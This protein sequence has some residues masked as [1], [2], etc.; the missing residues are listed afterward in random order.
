MA[1][2]ISLN[3]GAK[4]PP[5]LNIYDVGTSLAEIK[6]TQFFPQI[7][8]NSTFGEATSAALADN[9]TI[10]ITATATNVVL[11]ATINLSQSNTARGYIELRYLNGANEK[12]I[13]ILPTG[14]IT[15]ILLF[16]EESSTGISL[17]NRTDATIAASIFR[18]VG[19]LLPPKDL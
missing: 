15:T 9:A 3:P 17:T 4:T 14:L 19:L 8:D 7:T 2:F 11:G 6:Y 18:G 13:Q 10:T 12:V 16:L 1:L 5:I